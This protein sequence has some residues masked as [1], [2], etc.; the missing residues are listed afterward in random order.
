MLSNVLV[1]CLP[2]AEDVLHSPELSLAVRPIADSISFAIFM[3]DFLV[4]QSS[5]DFRI[6][7]HISIFLLFPSASRPSLAAALSAL[8]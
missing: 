5:F 4:S 7:P 1:I 2:F 3:G 6:V 8:A